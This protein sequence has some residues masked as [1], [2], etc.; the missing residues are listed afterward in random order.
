MTPTTPR[1]TIQ[2]LRWALTITYG[3]TRAGRIRTEDLAMAIGVSPRTVDRWLAAPVLTLDDRRLRQV[4]AATM[5]RDDVLRAEAQAL[6]Y[7]RDAVAG[8]GR[9]RGAGILPA[10]RK[11]NWLEPHMVAVLDLDQLGLRQVG[12]A[13]V[14]GRQVADLRRRGEVIDFSTVPTRLHATVLAQTVLD[15]V[16]AWRIRPRAG[17]VSVAPTRVFAADAP[18]TDLDGLAAANDLR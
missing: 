17:L 16:Q 7:A 18:A 5:P 12:I 13:R 8:L 15:T 9:G 11:Q 3:T 2:R 14:S 10:W 6:T 1:W 4:A